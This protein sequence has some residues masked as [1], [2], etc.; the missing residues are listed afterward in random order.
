MIAKRN[1][2]NKNKQTKRHKIWGHGS[3]IP[4]CI[5]GQPKTTCTPKIILSII[6]KIYKISYEKS[7]LEINNITSNLMHY[8]V[9]GTQTQNQP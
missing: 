4:T 1:K 7:Y 9:Q 2:N 6:Y 5:D 8:K 3:A